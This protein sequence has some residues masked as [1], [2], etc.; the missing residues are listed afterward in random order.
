MHSYATTF[1]CCDLHFNVRNMLGYFPIIFSR[2]CAISSRFM[3]E[4]ITSW[5]AIHKFIKFCQLSCEEMFICV[6]NH[7][8]A[9]KPKLTK[10]VWSVHTTGLM[11]SHNIFSSWHQLNNLKPCDELLSSDTSDEPFSS[12]TSQTTLDYAFSSRHKSKHKCFFPV[13]NQTCISL[14]L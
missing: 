3:H 13:K 5:P 2:N 4:N 1:L 8:V 7:N 9:I 10:L 6:T 12:N 14:F 11:D